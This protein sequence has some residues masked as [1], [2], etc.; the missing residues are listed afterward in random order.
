MTTREHVRPSRD[1][2][3]LAVARPRGTRVTS[4]ELFPTPPDHLF[5]Y[6]AL[7]TADEKTRLEQL[8]VG[9]EMYFS[10]FDQVN[11]P[12]DGCVLPD[13]DSPKDVIRTYWRA[14]QA[15]MGTTAEA[16]DQWVMR[17]DEPDIKR[18]HTRTMLE[19]VEETGIFCLVGTP[20]N[21]PMWSYYAGGH[22][23]VC[24][25]FRT[26]LPFQ[27]WAFQ[28]GIFARIHYAQAY[29][30]FKFFETTDE[31]QGRHL[32]FTKSA[33]WQHEDEWRIVRVK[34]VGLLAFPPE[35]LDAVIFGAKISSDD[36]RYVQ[37]LVRRR[38]VSTQLLEAQVDDRSF[39]LSIR[40]ASPS[41]TR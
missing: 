11:D 6:R 31:E 15:R 33:D 32:L 8:L 14:R 27:T 13:F 22:T 18:L 12:F 39:S 5:K 20:T 37:E 41:G 38:T 23:G 1:Q 24:L 7:T 21:V 35:Y 26:D 28:G 34:G 40:S 16:I 10:A 30:G 25:R 4:Q 36:R 3:P 19:M 2:A 9:S 17:S 29:P